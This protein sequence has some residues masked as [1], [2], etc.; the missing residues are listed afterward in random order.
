MDIIASIA[1]GAGA[2]WASG[3]NVYAVILALG[4]LGGTGHLVLPPDLQILTNPL[5]IAAAGFM[6]CVEFFAD[7]TPGVDSVW[8]A[9]HTFIRIPAGA[10]L[11]AGTFGHL[12]PVLQIV[13]FLLGGTLAATSHATKAGARVFINT[14]PEP[15]SNWTASLTEDVIAFSTIWGATQ[16]PAAWLAVLA[17]IMALTVW[18]LPKIW[19]GVARL[20][21]KLKT[22]LRGRT[23]RADPPTRVISG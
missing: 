19:S 22:W 1:L 3:I 17:V 4:V 23:E 21:V 6:Y 9:L 5:I 12:D 11:A 20:F 16:H 8:D 2:A 13:A 7:K 10:M 18:A 14:S 15:V